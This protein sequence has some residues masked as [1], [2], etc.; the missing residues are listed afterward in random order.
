MKSLIPYLI[1]LS[2]SALCLT[3][4]SKYLPQV[5]KQDNIEFT[6]DSGYILQPKA[7]RLLRAA[8]PDSTGLTYN[9][10]IN[11]TLGKYYKTISG[12]YMLC[13][14]IPGDPVHL[15]AEADL[16]G[17]IRNKEIFGMGMHHCCWN[18]NYEGFQ[19]HGNYFSV[20]TCGTG[21]GFCST[22]YYIFKSLIPQE[23]QESIVGYFWSTSCD[24]K[25]SCFMYSDIELRNDTVI[26]HYTLEKGVLKKKFKP[27]KTEKFD[28]IYTGK[29][30]KWIAS[31]STRLSDYHY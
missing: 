4:K 5:N 15:V 26:M 7:E 2:F 10:N 12:N 14:P 3:H 16:N 21:S 6:G 28:V 24:G 31:D 29:N 30:S 17:N 8:Y 23:K 20:K 18:N 9:T 1:V 27:R 19:K 22:E 11:D 25:Y 13:L